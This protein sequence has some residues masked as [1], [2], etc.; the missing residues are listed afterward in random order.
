MFVLYCG[1]KIG[2]HHKFIFD[3]ACHIGVCE[4]KAYSRTFPL[5]TGIR[6]RI[7]LGRECKSTDGSHRRGVVGD[8]V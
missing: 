5:A 2:A 7:D 8:L 3:G 4:L 1:P 6:D